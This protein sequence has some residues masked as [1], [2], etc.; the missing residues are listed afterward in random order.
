MS[1]ARNMKK[2]TVAKLAAC[3][4]TIAVMAALTA[5]CGGSKDDSASSSGDQS[6]AEQGVDVNRLLHESGGRGLREVGDL[7]SRKIHERKEK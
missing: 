3:V 4:L 1:K 5:G 6:A 7:R 2:K